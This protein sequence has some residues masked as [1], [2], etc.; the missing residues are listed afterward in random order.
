MLRTF[1]LVFSAC[2]RGDSGYPFVN[3]NLFVETQM[4]D[5][6]DRAR[7]SG[8]NAPGSRISLHY[9]R[10]DQNCLRG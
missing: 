1:T 5:P 10:D 4:Q 3:L 8:L 7:K 9:E 6:E 2:R